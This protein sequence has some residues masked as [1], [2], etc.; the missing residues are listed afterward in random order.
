MAG[1]KRTTDCGHCTLVF[2]LDWAAASIFPIPSSQSSFLLNRSL[3]LLLHPSPSGRKRLFLKQTSTKHIG[4]QRFPISSFLLQWKGQSRTLDLALCMYD[5]P[6]VSGASTFLSCSGD[7]C[8]ATGSCPSTP[9]PALGS[10]L[11]QHLSHLPF[12][13]LL[14]VPIIGTFVLPVYSSACEN[15]SGNLYPLN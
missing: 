9:T 12:I 2:I 8:Y 15:S 13:D 11:L 4:P 3:R 1:I 7:F 14:P 6:T 5:P 10:S